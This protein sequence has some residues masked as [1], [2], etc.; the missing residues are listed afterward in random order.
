MFAKVLSAGLIGVD[1]YLIDVEVDIQNHAMPTWALVGLADSEVK[2]SRERVIS[3]IKN[4]GY[5]CTYRK[6]I[7]NLAPADTKKQGTALDLPIA[8]G[9]MTASSL[10]SSGRLVDTMIVGELSLTGELRPVSGLLP[11]AILAKEKNI[12]RLVV[13]K[14]NACEA[15]MVKGIDVYG[16]E[17][18]SD[19]LEFLNG[20]IAQLPATPAAPSE[21]EPKSLCPVD[22]SDI[23]G[24]H[25]AKRAIEIA[26]AGGHNILLSG[27]PG[28]GKTMLAS[29][30]PTVL[31]SLSFEE[32]LETSKIYS[33]MGLLEKGHLVN[34][35]PFRHPHHS[36]ST[37][38]LI[39]GGSYP[40]PGEVSLAHNGVLFLDELPE[41]QRHVLELLRQPLEDH[42][43]TIARASMTLTFPSRFILV[44]SCNPCPC[45]FATHPR[46][47]CRCTPLI[48][49][50]YRDRLSGPLLDRIDLKVE[51]PPIDYRDYKQGRQASEP[52][53]KIKGRIQLVRHTQRERFKHFAL[54]LNSQMNTKLIEVFCPLEENAEKILKA[55]MEKYHLSGRGVSRV[56]K[57]AR[58]IADLNDSK[59]ITMDHLLEA[60]QYRTTEEGN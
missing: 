8:I 59:H 13:P 35:R 19:V 2:E 22:F 27:P 48:S 17:T 46:I 43:V 33:V 20:K 53:E 6:V 54:S 31:P 23:Y 34:T 1:A 16:L 47:Q 58:T 51:V 10:L 32:S 29:R 49:Q 37:S 12:A 24:Q 9:L 15:A 26:A 60:I 41:F 52:S 55:S 25:Q 40:K 56:L 44:A 14:D 42:K 39:G 7:V 36:I 21:D 30:I 45:G 5:D 11:I 57:V 38:G 50:R 4:S 28:S 18:L 3:A